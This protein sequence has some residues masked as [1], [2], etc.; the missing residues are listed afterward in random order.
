MQTGKHMYDYGLGIEPFQIDYIKESHIIQSRISSTPC[1]L[2]QLNPTGSSIGN[3][4]TPIEIT[5][6]IET[7]PNYK[8]I[9][10]NGIGEHPDLR[11]KTENN[12]NTIVVTIDEMQATRILSIDDLEN[13]NEFCIVQ[14]KDLNPR[15]VEIVFNNGFNAS[16]HSIE[17]YYHTIQ[18]DISDVRLKE[19]EDASHSLHG[20][21]QYLNP[22]VDDYQ[23]KNQILVRLP[24][25]T[26]DLT[27]NPE[28]LVVLQEHESWMIWTPYV[29]EQDILII[30]A[31]FSP[32][33]R[34]ERFEVND[35]KD[36]IIQRNLVSQRFK[37]KHLEY[38]DKRYLI[39]Y[40]VV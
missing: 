21:T 22:S 27:V 29:R 1:Y 30:P 37:L 38:S 8:A 16:T 6:Y 9:I 32:T 19:G 26:R 15:R 18:R 36:S 13:D 24:L 11:L 17:Y 23:D 2:L 20:W 28:G 31:Q 12:E 39:S 34:E 5:S 14:R 10:W 4:D 40:G 3:A 33:G 7:F 25:T 35:K